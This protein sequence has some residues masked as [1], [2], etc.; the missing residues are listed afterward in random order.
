MNN[1]EH[2]IITRQSKYSVKEALDKFEAL[3]SAKGI[4]VFT[5]IDQRAEA[6][7]V[8]M[9][10]PPTELIVFGNPRAGTPIMA[11]FPLAALDLPLKLLAWGQD[12]TVWL[13]YNDPAYL[14]QRYALPDEMTKKIDFRPLV[15]QIAIG[16]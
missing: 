1:S 12:D 6:K 9:D 13:A 7:K 4:T 11:A 16:S 15:D 5:R 8:G 14:Q 2:G 3:L 10:L